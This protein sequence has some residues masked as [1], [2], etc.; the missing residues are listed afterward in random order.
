MNDG[1]RV[2]Y[3]RFCPAA[4]GYPSRINASATPAGWTWI[5]HPDD[6]P[7][8]YAAHRAAA[9]RLM[10]RLHWCGGLEGGPFRNGYCWVV[11]DQDDD[12]RGVRRAAGP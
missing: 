12:G 1:R 4:E 10:D 9:Q 8:G 11:L 5:T 2:I 3:T 7:G 6:L